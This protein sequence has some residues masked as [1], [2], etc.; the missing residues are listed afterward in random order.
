[1]DTGPEPGQRRSHG[2][3]AIVESHRKHGQQH[4]RAASEPVGE[5]ADDRR[6][7]ELYGGIA[8]AQPASEDGGSV[9][10]G[11]TKLHDQ[12]GQHRNDDAEAEHVDQHDR[13][14]EADGTA[15]GLGRRTGHAR[16]V[17]SAAA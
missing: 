5:I 12:R 9:D 2:L 13:E 16:L 10:I 15:V 17:R 7:D 14:H 6:E 11:A 3:Q 1:M 4:D 8:R